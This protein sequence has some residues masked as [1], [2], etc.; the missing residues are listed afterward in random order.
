MP[1][2][3]VEFTPRTW[4]LLPFV[5]LFNGKFHWVIQCGFLC[6]QFRVERWIDVRQETNADS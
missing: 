4:Y 2:V 3:R 1:N 5:L 6:F